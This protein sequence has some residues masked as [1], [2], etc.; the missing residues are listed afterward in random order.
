MSQHRFQ[1]LRRQRYLG[2]PAFRTRRPSFNFLSNSPCVTFARKVGKKRTATRCP[3]REERKI[4]QKAGFIVALLPLLLTATLFHKPA[5]AGAGSLDPSFGE[6]G[7]VLTRLSN[8]GLSIC[9]ANPTDAVLQPDGRIVVAETFQTAFGA[10]R[11][12]RDGGLDTSFGNG[13]MAQTGLSTS[14]TSADSVA[15]QSDGKIVVAG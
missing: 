9:N 6:G 5:F 4:M 11:Y 15:L 1:P 12:L 13:G 14:F 10:M 8:C 7:K 2:A 3:N